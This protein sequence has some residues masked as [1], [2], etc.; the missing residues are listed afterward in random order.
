M[1]T[2]LAGIRAALRHDAGLRSA[3]GC[4]VSGD[5]AGGLAEAVD[6]ARGAEVAVICVG[7]KS[8]LMPDCTSGEFRDASDLGLTGLQQRLVKEVAATGTPVVMVLINGRPLALPW[9]AEHVPAVVEAWLPGEQAGHALAD[10]LF[11]RTSPAGRLPITLPRSVGQVPVFYGHKSGGGRS[12]MLGDYVDGPVA[13]LFPFGHGLAYTRFE[14]GSLEIRPAAP[15]PDGRVTIA[16]D[17]A[18]TGGREADEVVQLYLRD[19]VASVTRPV[20]QLAGFTR[21]GLRPG[22]ACRVEFELDLTQ[23]AFHDAR[24][25]L[26]VEAGEV[27]VMVGASSADLRLEGSFRVTG[28]RREVQRAEIA[29]TRVRVVRAGA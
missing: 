16:C 14:Y 26:V 25:K 29:P 23:L 17:V 4:D 9:I 12:Q 18:N 24:M 11:G 6:A 10:V 5:D 27:E 22:E 19:P 2:P 20:K 13:P 8:G 15:A 28:T 7:G 3:R 21:I 1:V